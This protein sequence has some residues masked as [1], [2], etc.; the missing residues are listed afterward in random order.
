MSFCICTIFPHYFLAAPVV[1][2]VS[3]VHSSIHDSET[4]FLTSV[5]DVYFCSKGVVIRYT[6]SKSLTTTRRLLCLALLKKYNGI[7][8]YI[9]SLVIWWWKKKKKYQDIN[10]IGT[11][12]RLHFSNQRTTNAAIDFC[13]YILLV[14]THLANLEIQFGICLT[15]QVCRIAH[16][17]MLK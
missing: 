11:Y 2:Y 10:H 9:L 8:D 15:H 4:G 17:Y 16:G 1:M 14:Y 3:P 13:S 12:V 7:L 5:N 6:G